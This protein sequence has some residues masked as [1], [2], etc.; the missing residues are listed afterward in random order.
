MGF[1]GIGDPDLLT[2][3]SKKMVD[4]YQLGLT[5]MSELCKTQFSETKIEMQVVLKARPESPS[6]IATE[7]Y[8]FFFKFQSTSFSLD[9]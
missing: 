8:L 4:R 5:H 6:H 2:L 7:R 9:T 3:A 1:Q